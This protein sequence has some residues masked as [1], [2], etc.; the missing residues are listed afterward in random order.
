MQSIESRLKSFPSWTPTEYIMSSHL[1][2]RRESKHG[3]KGRNGTHPRLRRA[4]KRAEWEH[5]KRRAA[6]AKHDRAF[7]RK[8]AA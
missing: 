2:L 1:L 6:I 3:A 5:Q 8:K 4:I 7:N